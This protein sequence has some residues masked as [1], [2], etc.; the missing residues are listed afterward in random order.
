MVKTKKNKVN[1]KHYS[2]KVQHGGILSTYGNFQQ[3]SNLK[4][5]SISADQNLT[6]KIG[7]TKNIKSYLES[8]MHGHKTGAAAYKKTLQKLKSYR[9]AYTSDMKNIIN[10]LNNTSDTRSKFSGYK[11][12]KALEIASNTERFN[13]I[14][15]ERN[16]IEQNIKNIGVARNKSKSQIEH[17][18]DEQVQQTRGVVLE[19][20]GTLVYDENLKLATALTSITKD[21]NAQSFRSA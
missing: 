12:L 5:G 11:K 14:R 16:T 1:S 4:V 10:T 15:T 8:P 3:A 21:P 7:E 2:K 17:E 20:V 9:K 13:N 6:K 19:H 18:L